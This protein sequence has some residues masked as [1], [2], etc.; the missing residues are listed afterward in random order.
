MDLTR[1][2]ISNTRTTF[3]FYL[4]IAGLGFMSYAAM[5]RAE[6][7]G[8]IIRAAQV[9]TVFPGASPE[10]VER[11]VTDKLEKA[12][13]EM[14]EVDFLQS[15]S[16]T[17]LSVIVVNVLESYTEMEPIWDDLRRKVER[18]AGGLPAGIIGP[19]VNDEFGD[20]FG[21][22]V[23]LAA[24][25]NDFEYVY[26]KD[27]AD[28]VRDEL[29]LISEV[30]KVQI[31][32]AQEERIFVEYNNAR[33]SEIG[34]SPV[35]LAQILSARNI[36]APG[37]DV[38]TESERIVLE[39]SGNF[40]SLDDLRNTVINL[41]GSRDLI[42][43]QDIA[44][45][46][47]GYIDPPESM[48][49]ASGSRSLALA[50]S[51]REGGNIL[52]LGDAVHTKIDELQGI[53][54]IGIEFDFIQ[55]QAQ[56]VDR[57]ISD[58]VGNL[59]Q[60]VVIVTLVMLAFLGLRTGMVVASLIP[61]TILMALWIM[62]LTGTG[63]DQISIAA[64][65]MALGMLV[66]N[67]I[68][69]SESIMTQMA[70]GKEGVQAA[71]DSAR[72]L[73]VPLLT[74]SL[75]T[76]AAFL[77]IYLAESSVG[78]YTAALFVVIT[79]TLLSSW[80]VTLT[81]IPLLCVMFVR[82]QARAEGEEG[83]YDS[84]F[85]RLYRA[86]LLSGLRHRGVALGSIAVVFV[87]AMNLFA[88]VPQI[89]FPPNER[90]TLTGDLLL[91]TGTPIAATERLA[92]RF[93]RFIA[94]NLQVGD[95]RPDGIVNWG[96]FIGQGAPRFILPYTPE[97]PRPEYATMVI[98]TTS[99]AEVDRVIPELE[100]FAAENFPDLKAVFIPLQLGP[101]AWPPVEVRISGDDPAVLF[102]IVDDVKEQLRRVPGTKNI[103]DDWGARTKKLL[104]EVDQPRA[105]RAGVSSQDIAVSLQ[106]FLTGIDT[107]EF[108]EDDKIIP[109]T[110][111]S[112][113]TQRNDIN[114]IEALNVY[115]QSTG[116]SVPLA[117]VADVRVEWQPALIHRRN[118]LDTVTVE[119]ALEPGYTAAD[120]DG[121]ITPWLEEQ[122]LRWPRG[123]SWSLGGADEESAKG[124]ASIAAK[125]PIAAMIILL[126]L[127]AQFNSIRK[128]LIILMT[129][130]MALIGV[131]LGL[132]TFN[133][134]FGFMT[135]LGVISLAGIVINNAIVLLDRIDI[136][137]NQNGMPPARA[138]VEAAQRRMRPILLTT[139][140]TIGGL[141]P[142]YLGGGAMWEPMAMT[143]MAGLAFAT[144]LTLGVVPILY[145][146][147]FGVSFK[148]FEF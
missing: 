89:F 71:I 53:Y 66:D 146:V 8:F 130:P 83:G 58:F 74:S 3:V 106:S 11:L 145:S 111:R 120:I 88:L 51:L 117:Q 143:I 47:R 77:P 95:G 116:R 21:T 76:C 2:A 12:I 29:L 10:R 129:I 62:G 133:L 115:S 132:L 24:D 61:T 98:N 57:L 44:D 56:E 138:V 141:L 19:T 136:E 5:S 60:A 147:M 50:I 48:V 37:G 87:V 67:A 39:P 42:L 38:I 92:E 52:A 110:L 101:P 90:A 31:F 148:G 139:T 9:T 40:E 33:L 70:E 43:L 75:T 15:E 137:I 65:I 135:L 14:P 28:E 140:T 84:R 97:N 69:M 118:R 104:I 119:S 91:P 1:F 73:R 85:Y 54:P 102:T 125:L 127:V 100:R 34:V 6:D 63:L 7:P 36:T 124:N 4:V 82:V 68:V 121:A 114:R 17:G 94:D 46:Q 123:Y 81:L 79:I 113:E 128:P 131:V 32:G 26:L 122:Q 22:I 49:R 105:L 103:D 142:L 108:R 144:V 64:L 112:V 16:K 23:T 20:V 134:Y 18:A 30:A 107:T 45:I 78:E 35:Q 25:E 80:V 93:D 13:Q 27:V 59:L 99:R 55:F 96:V 86:L 72:E 41:P 109:V 126:L